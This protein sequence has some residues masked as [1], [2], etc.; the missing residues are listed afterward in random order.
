[1]WLRFGD[2]E[3]CL[4][5][6][7]NIA[8]LDCIPQLFGNIIYWLLIFSGIV[9]LFIIIFSGIRFIASSG[10]P[11]QL[12]GAKKT[13]GFAIAGLLLI[14][15]SFFIIRVISQVTNVE[16]IRSFGLENCVGSFGEGRSSSG[17]FD[18]NIREDTCTPAGA[19]CKPN[20]SPFENE[21]PGLTC[22][23]RAEKCC[24]NF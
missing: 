16:C 7:D 14:I 2:I 24:S 9:A 11:K 21:E 13:F 5:G 20:C 4:I 17:S 19:D 22:T 1:M 3:G 6:T 15:F 8:T 23:S 12:E 10:D 18:S